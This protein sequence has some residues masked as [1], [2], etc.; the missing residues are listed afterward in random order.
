MSYELQFYRTADGKCPVDWFLDGLPERH[1][2]K[3]ERFME[4]LERKGPD[5][6][7]PY[8]DVARGKIRE[9]RIGFGHHEYRFLY[10]FSGK[11]IVITHGFLKKT[12]RL[13]EGEIDRAQRCMDEYL[14]RL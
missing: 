5:F 7:R 4:L 12:D 11:N 13:P 8:A 6:P 3:V 9:L 10:F 14:A 1:A 2:A